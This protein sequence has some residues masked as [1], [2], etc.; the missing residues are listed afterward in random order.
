MGM[1]LFPVRMELT[2]IVKGKTL[3]ELMGRELA[4]G[5]TT[6]VELDGVA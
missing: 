4:P 5:S 1:T 2:P 3:R 6:A